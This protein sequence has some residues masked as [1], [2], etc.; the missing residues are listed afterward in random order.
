MGVSEVLEID[1]SALTQKSAKDLITQT[2]KIIKNIKGVK[3]SQQKTKGKTK[4]LIDDQEKKD[5]KKEQ[6]LLKKQKEREKKQDKQFKDFIKNNSQNLSGFIFSTLRTSIPQL[7]AII[8]LTAII[9]SILKRINDIQTK[10]TEDVDDRINISLSNQQQARVNAN[11]QQIIIT[12]GDG[13]I[14][15][16]DAYNSLNESDANVAF[17]ESTYRL[18]NTSGYE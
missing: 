9:T 1:F 13:S 4:K 15:P 8:G 5:K 10:F 14:N 2:D 3:P 6:N 11:L 12:N 17:I 7:S 18:E 16:R